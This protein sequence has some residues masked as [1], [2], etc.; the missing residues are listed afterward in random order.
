[1]LP[2]PHRRLFDRVDGILRNR[3]DARRDSLRIEKER[4]GATDEQQGHQSKAR[5][6]RQSPEGQQM[7]QHQ[8][9]ERPPDQPQ[10][11]TR[12]PVDEAA[13]GLVQFQLPFMRGLGE[14]LLEKMAC[15]LKQILED[16]RP[17]A[18]HRLG[19]FPTCVT[20]IHAR[21]RTL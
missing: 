19:L 5:P 17:S 6:E 21:P 9:Q 20:S 12:H 14:F 7:R 18:V 13:F 10:G 11:D 16:R 15:G 2:D 8:D 4:D 3:P 1:M